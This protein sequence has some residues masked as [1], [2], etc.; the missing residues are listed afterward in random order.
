MAPNLGVKVRR[1]LRPGGSGGGGS[2]GG[3]GN[4]GRVV[5]IEVA[6]RLGAGIQYVINLPGG[7]VRRCSRGNNDPAGPSGFGM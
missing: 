2:D 1:R 7:S 4:G 5:S 3:E 6:D